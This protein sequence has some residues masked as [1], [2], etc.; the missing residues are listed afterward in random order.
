MLKWEKPYGFRERYIVKYEPADLVTP[1]ATSST[2]GLSTF[3]PVNVAFAPDDTPPSFFQSGAPALDAPLIE[4][5]SNTNSYLT[6]LETKRRRR[7]RQVLTGQVEVNAYDTSVIIENLDPDTNYRF[8]ITAES[9][10]KVSQGLAKIIATPKNFCQ[11]TP[12]VCQGGPGLCFST[13]TA[14]ICNC[15]R[16]YTGNGIDACVDIDECARERTP[17]NPEKSFC[18][19]LEGSYDCECKAGF[20]KRNGHCVDIDECETVNCVDEHANDINR[21]CLNTFG[22]YKCI[23]DLGLKEDEDSGI[24]VDIDECVE[25][26]PPVVCA[27]NASCRNS[28][29]AHSCECNQGYRG[30]GRLL[31]ED[32]NEC[33]EN[34][35]N[36]ANADECQNIPGGYECDCKVGYTKH[37]LSLECIDLNECETVESQKYCLSQGSYVTCVN[38]IG[39][40]SCQC[41]EGFTRNRWAV[42]SE[43]VDINECLMPGICSEDS[44]CKN[45]LGS[46]ECICP[47]GHEMFTN[48]VTGEKMCTDIDECLDYTCSGASICINTVGSFEC[49]CPPG[50]Q[51]NGG[52][53]IC[54][55][56]DECAVDNNICSTSAAAGA[57]LTGTSFKAGHGICVN[58]YGSYTCKCA[59]GFEDR[60]DPVTGKTK[61][62]DIDEC[63]NGEGEKYCQIKNSYCHNY[64]G[65]F[66][67]RCRPGYIGDAYIACVDEDECHDMTHECDRKATCRNTIGSYEC[68]CI[69]GYTSMKI[70][71]KHV[72]I[73]INECVENSHECSTNAKCRNLDGSY[74]CDCDTGY[75]GDGRS[76][77]DIDECATNSHNCHPTMAYCANVPGS[78]ICTCKPGFRGDGNYCVDIDECAVGSH[79]CSTETSTCVNTSGSYKCECFDG[80]AGDTC[81]DINEC[82]TLGDQVCQNENMKCINSVGSYSCQCQEGYEEIDGKCLDIDE[83][84]TATSCHRY[85]TCKNTEGS[86]ECT[87]KPGYLGDGKRC[88]LYNVCKAG[89]HDCHEHAVCST[90]EI[91]EYICTCPGG[92]LGDGLNCVDINECELAIHTCN[93]EEECVNTVGSF[94]CVCPEG[95]RRDD[96]TDSCV[97]VNECR[98]LEYDICG[99]FGDCINTPG[100]FTCNC[101]KGFSKTNETYCEDIDECSQSIQKQIKSGNRMIWR[102]F[103]TCG[104]NSY[105]T[106]TPGS[107]TC[108]CFSG[109]KRNAE[110]TCVDVDECSRGGHLL[111]DRN[112]KCINTPGSYTCLCNLGYAGTGEKCLQSRCQPAQRLA[113]GLEYTECWFGRCNLGCK[114][115]YERNMTAGGVD[116]VTCSTKGKFNEQPMRCQ[117]IN[118]CAENGKNNCDPFYGTC[119]VLGYDDFK[120]SCPTGFQLV[121]QLSDPSDPKGTSLQKCVDINE[122]HQESRCHENAICTNELG[123]YSCKCKPGYFGNG[124]TCNDV[125]ECLQRNVCPRSAFCINLKGSF[126]CKCRPGWTMYED[127]CV[128]DNSEEACKTLDCGEEQRCIV[129]P[130]SNRPKCICPNGT[131][132]YNRKCLPVNE[133]DSANNVCPENS[134]CIDKEKGYSC[135]CHEGYFKNANSTCS[136]SK[137]CD[138]ANC[139][140]SQKCVGINLKDYRCECREGYQ[141]S[142]FG[143]CVDIDECDP[144]L[145]DPKLRESCPINSECVNTQGSYECNCQTGYVKQG[146]LCVDINECHDTVN[147]RCPIDAVCLNTLGSYQCLCPKG[148]EYNAEFNRC[149][150]IDECLTGESNCSDNA[151]CSNIPGSYICTCNTGYRGSGLKDQDGCQDINECLQLSLN[152]CHSNAVCVNNIGSYTCKCKYGYFG[153]GVDSCIEDVCVTMPGQICHPQAKCIP[154]DKSII[155]AQSQQTTKVHSFY[156]SPQ[157]QPETFRCECRTGF[158]GDG[159]TS[160]VDI[161]ECT[162]MEKPCGDNTV[163]INLEGSYSCQCRT[164]YVNR[165]GLSLKTGSCSLNECSS[166]SLNNCHEKS[167]C[168]DTAESYTCKCFEG[169][170]GNGEICQEINEC[171]GDLNICVEHASC[172]DKIGGI[173]CICDIGFEGDGYKL[174]ADKNE[175]LNPNACPGENTLCTNTEGSFTC[176]CKQGFR[177]SIMGRCEDVNECALESTNNCHANAI[178]TN[179]LG[180]Y[181]CQCKDGFTGDGQNCDDIDECRAAV[182]P[183]SNPAQKCINLPGS[184][185]CG[186]P[187][188]FKGP[189]PLT[190]KCEDINECEV[191]PKACH[192]HAICTNTPGS[193]TCECKPGFQGNAKTWCGDINECLIKTSCPGISKC[194]NTVSSFE[195]HC[196]PGYRG[197][198]ANCIDID[199]CRAVPKKCPAPASCKN[200][201][202][203]YQCTCPAGYKWNNEAGKCEDVDECEWMTSRPWNAPCAKEGGLC[204]NKQGSYMCMCAKGFKGDGKTCTDIDECAKPGTCPGKN[205]ICINSPGSYS[206]KQLT[207]PPTVL[208]DV[209]I[210]LDTHTQIGPYNLKFVQEFARSIVEKLEVG[211]NATSISITAY[212]GE[213]VTPLFFLSDTATK[214]K[215]IALQAVTRIKHVGYGLRIEKA[216][217]FLL[218]FSFL[219][220][221]GRKTN[222][223]GIAIVLASQKTDSQ[224]ALKFLSP[225]LRRA[226]GKYPLGKDLNFIAVGVQDADKDDLM[227]V[228]G[229]KEEN[230]VM[231][232]TWP[233]LQNSVDSVLKIMCD[234]TGFGNDE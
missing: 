115:G 117:V 159:K 140:S 51:G 42:S 71:E 45:T 177:R 190:N 161:N 24:C 135:K 68:D 222:R 32:I 91:G 97:D 96:E 183:C 162:E 213:K 157:T 25:N 84:K 150:D 109:Y 209:A 144:E 14:A 156:S 81:T 60:S 129:N 158:K 166:P 218:N 208:A 192:Q 78:F 27:E 207:C 210:V 104:Q 181:S 53:G 179:T 228:T 95:Y 118:P 185:Q 11:A 153:D 12:D 59:N 28:F 5:V 76:C 230:I 106:N 3:G 200:L 199:E 204:I 22:S 220:A 55:D 102:K 57:S 232:N 98:D 145:K 108:E 31:C 152:D 48:E 4:P 201:P 114:E 1:S 90:P 8:T 87:C 67:C 234:I 165:S 124:N 215:D 160:C 170:S 191:D 120:C 134:D 132:I 229:N 216:L 82:I 111:C 77:V 226:E 74:N 89:L 38:E 30:N 80:Y 193:Y 139:D 182:S 100:S 44:T 6:N 136:K 214:G 112:A 173:N 13:Y 198:A 62:Q 88:G 41:R 75:H 63:A 212:S 39:G 149:M 221:M 171:S 130:N 224:Q 205:N 175:C 110:G 174:C 50:F 46:Y 58:T 168:I 103:T 15:A 37:P 35:H 169:Y 225:A 184:Y 86:Y 127:S 202:G 146:G 131:R 180:S 148:Y 10:D 79:S 29:S 233:D 23:C 65:G 43:C 34:L 40:F 231:A 70:G 206:C 197:Q 94:Q 116:L 9:Y 122:C 107:Y 195:C 119:T 17:C 99:E 155:L 211:S 72:C 54:S 21:K 18:V 164:N 167:N 2:S 19:N 33:E 16:G 113:R 137:A 176:G 105:C 154:V 101:P 83:C 151:Y 142:I 123:G 196:P 49:Q 172:I 138:F 66:E 186:C 69:P 163:C 7:R 73:D 194:T 56:V 125:N 20:E 126:K 187:A 178:C 64:D 141:K 219:P 85:A 52:L 217:S 147:K 121:N 36:C 203:S 26:D 143:T 93:D 47:P 92:F 128:K 223:P 227:I 189:N 188:G 133:C 61:C